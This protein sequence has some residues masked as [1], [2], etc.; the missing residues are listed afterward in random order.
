MYQVKRVIIE[1]LDYK[2]YQNVSQNLS[3]NLCLIK[4]LSLLFYLL[5]SNQRNCRDETSNVINLQSLQ[6][7]L[8]SC[9]DERLIVGETRWDLLMVLIL[10]CVSDAS[11]TG[12]CVVVRICEAAERVLQS[13]V[14]LHEE[15]DCSS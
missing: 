9:N 14:A 10:H 1:F 12:L 5:Y 4:N 11:R 8:V 13:S 7:Q 6:F 15:H 3:N 2:K